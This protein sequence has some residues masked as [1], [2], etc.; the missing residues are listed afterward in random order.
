MNQ[1]APSV[2]LSAI[3]QIAITVHDLD[4]AVTFYQ[5]TLGMKLLF[6]VPNLAFFDC[7]GIRLML[8]IPEKPEF[9]HPAS[10][11]YYKVADLP[12][13]HAALVARNVKFEA[14]PHLIAK[15]PDH[16]LWMAFLRDSEGNLLGL[17]SEVK[18][19]G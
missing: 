2:T 19:E 7:S 12:S 4:R 3:G 8:T 14:L 17:M 1:Q 13:V 15:M 11:I 6:R 10:V 16:D 9:D 5:T 18:H